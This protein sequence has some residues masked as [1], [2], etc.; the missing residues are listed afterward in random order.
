MPCFS[1][2]FLLS[3]IDGLVFLGGCCC[4]FL[5]TRVVCVDV[6]F[7]FVAVPCWAGGTFGVGMFTGV[8]STASNTF[9]RW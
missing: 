1:L 8:L 3:L 6:A 5:D 2:M 9:K 7:F 4:S